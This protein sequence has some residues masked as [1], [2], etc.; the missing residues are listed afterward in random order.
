[1]TRNLVRK[2]LAYALGR[3]LE[4]RDDGTIERISAQLAKEGY[5][6]HTLIEQIVLST[7]FRAQQLR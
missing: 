2:I 5:G 1:M 4:D 7:Q 3:A 6:A